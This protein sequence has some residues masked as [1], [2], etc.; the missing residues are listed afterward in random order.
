[1]LLYINFTYKWAR[2][3]WALSYG[4]NGHQE[5]QFAMLKALGQVSKSSVRYTPV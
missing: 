3:H 5:V 4:F 2:L 1:M